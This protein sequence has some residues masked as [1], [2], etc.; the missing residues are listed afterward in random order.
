MIRSSFKQPARPRR[1]REP[2]EFASFTPKPR[3]A[4]MAAALHLAEPASIPKDEPHY[5][6]AW[7]QAVASLGCCVICGKHGVQVAH[8]NEG[9]ALAAKTDDCLTAALCPA[10][11]SEIDQG[12]DL[13]REQR[14]ERIDSAILRTLVLLFRAG[15]VRAV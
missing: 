15:K 14:R 9:K 12:R 13:T 11:H 3:P 6:S 1:Q 10:C 4:V 2:D 5:S 7:R 8:R